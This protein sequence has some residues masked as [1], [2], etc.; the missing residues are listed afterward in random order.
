MV[1]FHCLQSLRTEGLE[2]KDPVMGR[3]A[4]GA[5]GVGC[6][7]SLQPERGYGQGRRSDQGEAHL[8][9]FS[10]PQEPALVPWGPPP[11]C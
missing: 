2:P 9:C 4:S 3:E 11:G 8:G 1:W 6:Q 5:A 7:L 10:V